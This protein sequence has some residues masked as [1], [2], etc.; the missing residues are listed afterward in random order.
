M[1]NFHPGR[2]LSSKTG[3]SRQ[4]VEKRALIRNSCLSRMGEPGLRVISGAPLEAP[5]HSRCS[6]SVTCVDSLGSPS[7]AQKSELPPAR[8]QPLLSLAPTSRKP[9]RRQAPGRGPGSFHFLGPPSPRPRRSSK[10]PGACTRAGA[11]H[12][13]VPQGPEAR[14]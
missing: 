5:A 14:A 12:F 9:S 4:W 2:K 3:R 1:A 8:L 7:V 11:K 13:E 10:A 6:L